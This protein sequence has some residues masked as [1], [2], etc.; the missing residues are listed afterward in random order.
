MQK[1]KIYYLTYSAVIAAVYSVLTLITPMFSFGV[2]QLR[3]SEALTVLPVFTPCAVCGLSVGCLISNILGF[4]LGQTPVYDIFFG[5]AATL[6]SSIVTFYIGKIKN[7]PLKTALAPLPPV[8]F[9]AVIIGIELT[10]FYGGVLFV[11]MLAVGASEVISCYILGEV[12]IA[13][14]NKYEIFKKS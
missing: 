8:L 9:N 6:L 14:L 10:V 7:K 13:V 11:N 2:V 3:I 1:Q 4:F 5:T 12:L